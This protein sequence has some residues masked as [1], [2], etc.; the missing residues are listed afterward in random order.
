[1]RGRKR[2]SPTAQHTEYN[3]VCSAVTS[4]YRC[5]S[6]THT[7][8]Y[9]YMEA[10]LDTRNQS[11]SQHI[12][13]ARH[14]HGSRA[15]LI[16]KQDIYMEAGLSTR[17]SPSSAIILAQSMSQHYLSTSPA[18]MRCTPVAYEVVM[19]PKALL[20]GAPRAVALRPTAVA[21]R[22]CPSVSKINKGG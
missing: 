3:T 14:I 7:Y 15:G 1:M 11:M 22:A 19:R 9:I 4:Q 6:H 20:V 10:G 13:A 17:Y 12:Y 8:S 2:A 5:I 21:M 18:A 16:C